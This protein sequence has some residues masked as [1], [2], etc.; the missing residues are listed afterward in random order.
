MTWTLSTELMGAVLAALRPA[1]PWL[2]MASG[3]FLFLDD[4]GL[5]TNRTSTAVTVERLEPDLVV[6]TLEPLE[7]ASRDALP[8]ITL[9]FPGARV[10]ESPQLLPGAH[11]DY[12]SG[13]H[14]GVDFP[15]ARGTAVHAVRAGR[16]LWI[17]QDAGLSDR[18]RSQL[19][20]DCR[21]IGA[22][23]EQILHVLHGRRVVLH[24]GRVDG[25]LLTTSYSH[26]D[27]VRHDLKPGQSV[28][29]GELLGW[30]GASGTSHEHRDDGWGELHLEVRLNGQTIGDGL[31]AAQVAT[32]YR[33][34]FG[35]RGRP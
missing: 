28:A 16:V 18:F 26:L 1:L 10:P 35:A 22:T 2:L 11:R 23:P 31:P 32:L 20:D 8:R 13:R 15:C 14:E 33:R 24:H 9:P 7:A 30:A 34:L 27:S 29:E 21:E 19:L 17:E 5:F 12:R 6:R 25:Q 4:I 3:L